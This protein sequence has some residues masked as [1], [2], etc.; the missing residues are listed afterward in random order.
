MKYYLFDAEEENIRKGFIKGVLGNEF[1]DKNY[2]KFVSDEK[3]VEITKRWRSKTVLKIRYFTVN[4]SYKETYVFT[5]YYEDDDDPIC[6]TR[7]YD[8]KSNDVFLCP[9]DKFHGMY[10]DYLGK[11]NIA[12]VKYCAIDDIGKKFKEIKESEVQSE[13]RASDGS[14]DVNKLL[15]DNIDDIYDFIKNSNDS[16]LK[17]AQ[18]IKIH[19]IKDIAYEYATYIWAEYD[20]R[21]SGTKYGFTNEI[22]PVS[23][24]S[25]TEKLGP[26]SKNTKALDKIGL[27][28]YIVSIV[29]AVALVVCSV[30][31][32]FINSES[33]WLRVICIGCVV[34]GVAFFF[35]MNK[36]YKDLFKY[37]ENPKERVVIIS[38]M[39]GASIFITVIGVAMVV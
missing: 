14:I 12:L 11:G 26:V 7:I 36:L 4:V 2:K 32:V 10:Y 28:A 5:D 30:L 19:E 1:I 24:S 15:D 3:N 33:G 9:E 22:F 35:G 39:F 34:G 23:S 8:T 27:A 20:V 37:A 25:S 21:V 29:A 13:F 6:E 17:D 38:I 16:I 31:G 18:K